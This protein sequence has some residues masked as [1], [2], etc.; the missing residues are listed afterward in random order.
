MVLGGVTRVSRLTSC[1][2]A[3]CVASLLTAGA[4]R[5][6]DDSGSPPLRLESRDLS[7]TWFWIAASTT[8]ITASLGGFYALHV[9]DLYDQAMLQPLVSPRRGELRQEMQTAELTADVLLL[10]SIAFAVGTTILAFHIDWSG[11][12]RPLAARADPPR[13]TWW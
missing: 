2:R 13:R 11:A 1:A 5:A 4:A 3:L 9:R 8:I 10:S 7:P 6:Q 12:D